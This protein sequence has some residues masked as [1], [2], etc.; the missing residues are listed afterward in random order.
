MTTRPSF[1]RTASVHITAPARPEATSGAMSSRAR[2]RDTTGGLR[3]L[4]SSP[5]PHEDRLFTRR[6]ARIVERLHLD[7]DSVRALPAAPCRCA[8]APAPGAR[9]RFGTSTS[10]S[11]ATATVSRPETAIRYRCGFSCVFMSCSPIDVLDFPALHLPAQARA[12]AKHVHLERN[13]E[14]ERGESRGHRE[15]PHRT[16]TPAAGRRA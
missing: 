16:R 15:Q 3:R 4:S 14:I 12:V 2:A 10:A 11:L 13:A 1:V 8:A 5:P 7:H 6:N 9:W